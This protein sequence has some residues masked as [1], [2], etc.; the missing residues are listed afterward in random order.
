MEYIDFD[1]IIEKKL[2]GQVYQICQAQKWFYSTRVTILHDLDSRL[3][4]RFME[5]ETWNM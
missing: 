3:F 4:I 2:N 5:I 1:A